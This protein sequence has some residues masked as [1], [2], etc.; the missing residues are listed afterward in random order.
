MYVKCLPLCGAADGVLSSK[1]RP[2][3]NLI[4]YDM[5]F[6]ANQVAPIRT[7]KMPMPLCGAA[8]GV[9]S[10]QI[11]PRLSK[12]ISAFTMNRRTLPRAQDWL[13][14]DCQIKLSDTG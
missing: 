12:L 13:I 8:D 10:S 1:I 6:S 2:R 14:S 7:M 9:M 11:R 4:G 3:L 5:F